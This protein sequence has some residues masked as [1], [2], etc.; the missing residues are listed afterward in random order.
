SFTRPTP[1]QRRR[2]RRAQ[3]QQQPAQGG[4]FFQVASYSGMT[5]KRNSLASLVTLDLGLYSLLD[6]S[7]AQGAFDTIN[8][9][10]NAVISDAQ[11]MSVKTLVINVLTFHDE[12]LPK[13]TYSPG[14]STGF[15]ALI[16]QLMTGIL[17]PTVTSGGVS[18]ITSYNMPLYRMR[19]S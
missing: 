10:V 9:F 16:A 7:T 11:S 13:A 12:S 17:P 3:Q 19:V 5:A 8:S 15:A 2:K 18:G 14:V 4:S 1:P 6:D